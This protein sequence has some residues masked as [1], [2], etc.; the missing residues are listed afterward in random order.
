MSITPAELPAYLEAI[1]ARV[2]AAAVPVVDAI[3]ETYKEHLVG[4]TLRESGSHPPVTQTPAVP[5]RPPAFMTG[6]LAGSVTR[7]PGAGEGGIA[8]SA[9]SP[10]TIYAATIQW[11]GV[12]TGKPW[13]WLWVRYIG[14]HEVARRGWVKHKVEIPSYPYMNVAVDETI[15]NGSLSRAGEA[16]FMEVVWGR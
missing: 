16:R 5:G 7:T 8:E 4:F 15:A 6:G 2:E 9:V 14:P 13:M 11:G 12:H 10:H 1:R 3:A